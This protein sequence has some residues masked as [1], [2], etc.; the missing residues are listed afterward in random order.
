MVGALYYPNWSLNDA[1]S[2]GEFLLYWDRLTFLTPVEDWYF[3]VWNDDVN[4]EKNLKKAHEKHALP[5]TPTEPE[6]NKCD[7]I[8]RSLFGQ[9]ED[10]NKYA[11]AIGKD[12]YQIDVRKLAP[13]TVEF[14]E[15]HKVLRHFYDDRYLAEKA[16]GQLVMAVLAYCCSSEQLPPVTND[17]TEFTLQMLSLDDSNASS[18]ESC[19]CEVPSID[20]AYLMLVKR[21]KLPKAEGDDPQFLSQVIEAREKDEVNGYRRNFQNTINKFTNKLMSI[22]TSAEINDILAE[23][24]SSIDTDL[25]KLQKELRS[26]GVDAVI[27]KEGAIAIG[28]G[29]ILSG[30]SL[31]T[32]ALGGTLLAWRSYRKTRQNVL[33]K[34]WT[35]W[36][37][38][39][40]HPHFS[41]W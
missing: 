17:D 11:E 29:V 30:V 26:V 35:S 4:V 1:I 16:G 34:R 28:T 5:H 37:F 19:E 24:D 36:L 33:K 39:I 2:L 13:K 23:F 6:K 20:T 12:P 14:L 38:N 7:K 27:S 3:P 41:I 10:F 31:G 32:G 8:I 9:K 15:E 40:R 21:I 22:K 25:Q 18:S